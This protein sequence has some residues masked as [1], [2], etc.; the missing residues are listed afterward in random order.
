[1]N[2][3][4]LPKKTRD[5]VFN[6]IHYAYFLNRPGLLLLAKSSYYQIGF[7]AYPDKIIIYDC[8]KRITLANIDISIEKDYPCFFYSREYLKLGS[9]REW[10]S[11][12]I[13]ITASGKLI[14]PYIGLIEKNKRREAE[15]FVEIRSMDD[16]IVARS[17][18]G[19]S[20]SLSHDNNKII[21]V[22]RGKNG[23]FQY[24]MCSEN[25]DTTW[26]VE[27]AGFV[28]FTQSGNIIYH[29]GSD[30]VLMNFDRKILGRANIPTPVRN[31][32]T[33][34]NDNYA[35]IEYRN[36]NSA[37]VNLKTGKVVEIPGSLMG[38]NFE[39]QHITIYDREKS[40]LEQAVI[41][42]KKFEGTEVARFICP[43]N[44]ESFAFNSASKSLLVKSNRTQPSGM[45]ILYL[46]DDTLAVRGS[47]FLTPNDAFDFSNDGRSFY[48]VRDNELS[49][50]ENK[51][52][53]DISNYKSIYAWLEKV[54]EKNKF[55]P[56][57]FRT[58]NKLSRFP[59]QTIF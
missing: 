51:S 7:E 6:E 13:R 34:R 31:I 57:A 16:E 17:R 36:N 10:D 43:K 40:N 50:Y 24:E 21:Y 44:F 33:G 12:K 15:G 46:L 37:I 23:R 28:D 38:F 58:S 42:V 55:D 14:V 3:M 47:F 56:K 20:V 49:T 29:R 2:C 35:I 8:V 39:R 32:L 26:L 5:T 41:L 4:T 9:N 53:L 48:F 59:S 18:S 11:Y 54:E 27:N 19:F 45:Q 25:G 52:F 1:M 22:Y 30:L